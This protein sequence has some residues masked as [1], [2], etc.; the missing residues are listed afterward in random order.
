MRGRLL[1]ILLSLTVVAAAC[2][3]DGSGSEEADGTTTEPQ[4]ETSGPYEA[5]ITRTEHN[6]PHISADDLGS[7]GFGY[8][9]AFA[10]DHLC[11][12]ADVVVQANGEGA[13]HHGEEYV[14]QD[15][16][17]S[18]L[19]IVRT[20]REEFDGLE[21]DVQAV[22]RGYAAGYN[23][24]LDETGV[25][26]VPGYCAGEDW[27]R[28]IDEYD[29]AAYYKVLSQRASVDP[30][31]DFIYAAAPPTAEP[32]T[33]PAGEDVEEGEGE[34]EAAR[35][36]LVPDA[37]EL[38]SN[39]WAIGPE[40]TADGT[41][42]LAG[43][44]HFPW[45]GALRF[46]EVHLTVPGT[47]DVYGAS[48]LGSPAVNIGFND[49]VA[50][51]HTVSAGSRF[52]AYTLDL[53]EG[54]PT[55]YVYDDEERDLVPVE[56][57]VEVLAE[58]GST[59]T[60]DRTIW[61]SHYGP[62][63]DFPGVGWSEDTVLTFR[64]ANADNDEIIPQFFAMNTASSM[65]EFI[66]AH[67][68]ISGIPWVNT[69][70]A[71]AEGEVWYA[72]TSAA[73]NLSAE[74][75]TRWEQL[76]EDD[77]I[78]SIALDNGVILLDGSDSVF[79]WVEEE[80]ARDPG[81]VPFEDMPMLE[82]SDYVFNANDPY[83]LTNPEE[84]FTLDSPVFGL[85]EQPVSPRTRMNAVQLAEDGGGSGADGLYTLDELAA[86]VFSN[87]VFTAER[88]VDGVVERCRAAAIGV[89]CDVLADWDRHVDLDSRGA[90]LW[91]EFIDQ[92]DGA[93]LVDQ[94]PLW[95]EPFDPADP[96]GTP[97]GLAP[98]PGDG[99]DPVLDALQA[100]ISG[101][102]SA[103][104]ALD[105]PLGEVQV[106]DRGGEIV[107][108]HGGTGSEG[109]TNVVGPGSN[110]TTTE[111][112]ADPGAPIEGTGLTTVGYPIANGTSF[113][114]VLE[115]T[116]DGPVARSLLTYGETGDPTSPFF[117]DQ[118]KRFSAKDWK[119]VRFGRELAGDAVVDRYE[120]TAPR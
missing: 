93:A 30:L 63:I 48:L 31:V 87:R 57:S 28:P 99:T 83:W 55:K 67:R 50:W 108:V 94:G 68:D 78:T 41:T 91:R 37:A 1:P 25:A 17:Y 103:G 16:V 101:M 35:A 18:A 12:L 43:N 104:L 47:L 26:N 69:I 32:A 88:L 51:T 111:D 105:V 92:F 77:P 23:E 100:A 29:L 96:V 110:D 114:Y 112:G 46:Y 97:A 56:V 60:V 38:G 44:P 34:D 24:Y 62:V 107:P 117:S 2:S 4:V 39:G 80:G 54:D 33:E 52:T 79:E 22:I 9:Y 118:T 42:M 10:Q 81:L 13:R 5:T 3:D 49:A 120:V 70:A 90:V 84:L 20:A 116:D 95:A 113:V 75:V 19:D 74:A 85:A 61:F 64:D 53:V 45:Q 115:F 59:E 86:S 27:V 15:A 58:D 14:A 98:P 72:D 89:A 21:P 66:G 82:R 7:L 102:E 40:R 6:V 71:S 8:G 11:S 106:A 109:V 36:T 76:L 73:P 119:P 65:E